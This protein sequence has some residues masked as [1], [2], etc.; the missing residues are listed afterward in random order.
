MNILIADDTKGLL[1]LLRAKASLKGHDIDVVY[2]GNKALE[3][4]KSDKYDLVF[5]DHNMPKV[6]GS[7]LI[8]YIR[9]NNLKA[10]AVLFTGDP[11]INYFIAKEIGADEYL[12][13]PIR[14]K[15]IEHIVTKYLKG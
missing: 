1:E 4:I 14:I 10:K 15:D 7:E 11:S 8:K 6:T 2:D 13:K 5:L 9:E 12:S 3:Y